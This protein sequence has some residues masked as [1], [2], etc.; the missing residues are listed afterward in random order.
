LFLCSYLQDSIDLVRA[1]H[2]HR[3]RPK[4]VGAGMIGPQNTAVKTALGPLLNGFVN[5]EYWVPVS[6]MMFPG[7]QEFLDTYQARAG[8]AGV[9]LLGHYMAPLAFAQM[10][11]VAQA[12]E[13]TGGFDDAALSAYTREAIFDT[14]MGAVSFGVN[15]EWARPR[16]LQVQF[17]G[18]S[19]H[20]A[21]QFRNGSRQ[22]VVSPPDFASGELIFPYAQARSAG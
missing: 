20:E 4:M 16:V 5:Y 1:I 18:I 21:G 10:Q 6:R 9:D 19:G 3:F 2:A 8:D 14:V 22:I 7:V 13:A 11:V 12:I 15:G 17:Q